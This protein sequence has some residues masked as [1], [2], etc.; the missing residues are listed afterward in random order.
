MRARRRTT[1]RRFLMAIL[2]QGP[3]VMTTAKSMD[4]AMRVM[5]IAKSLDH[6]KTEMIQ[7]LKRKV[8]TE[9]KETCR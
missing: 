9:E 3:G 5:T 2:D 4:Q 1:L 8:T 6:V 7:T